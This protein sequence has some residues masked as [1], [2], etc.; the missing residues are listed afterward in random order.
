MF[1]HIL[2]PLDG[3][4]QAESA[5]APAA[6]LARRCGADVLLLS[7]TK[8]H[9]TFPGLL[10]SAAESQACTIEYYLSVTATLLRA[11]EV[12]V[13][14]ALLDERPARGIAAQSRG[15]GIDLIV[16]ATHGRTSLAALLHPSVTWAIL[17]QSPVPVLALKRSPDKEECLPEPALPRFLTAP[18]APIIVPLDGSR[19]AEHALPLAEE[20]ARLYAHPLVLVRAVALPYL[21]GGI[22]DYPMTLAHLQEWSLEEARGYL[23]RKQEELTRTGL[24][25]KT[26]GMFGEAV[27]STLACVRDE[28]AGLV[29]MAS[30][31]RSGLSH[32]FFGSVARRLLSRVTVPL[33][34]VPAAHL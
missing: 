30:H 21:A 26:A 17:G 33:L 4:V 7:T 2:V 22:I 32:L 10:T 6:L 20:F 29:V 1:K 23:K 11:E 19:R 31:G 28:Q 18:T 15:R 25:V 3:S 13:D 8:V 16:M 9:N 27:A 34:L 24:E 5:L 12:Q 14:T